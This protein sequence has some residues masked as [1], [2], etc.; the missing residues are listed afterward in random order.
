MGDGVIVADP[1]DRVVDVNPA[2]ENI[3]GRP[4]SEAVGMTLARLAPPGR[5][6][7][8]N[9]GGRGAWSGKRSGATKNRRPA[10][11]S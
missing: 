6:P 3:L 7:S 2:A 4:A 8:R 10:T 5:P 9:T 11:T 1:Q